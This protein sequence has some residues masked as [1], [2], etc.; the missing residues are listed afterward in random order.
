MEFS[1]IFSW[2][3]RLVNVSLKHCHI[4]D[5]GLEALAE[6]CSSLKVANLSWCDLIT[7]SGISFLSRN[8]RELDTLDINFC[9]NITGIGFLGCSHTLTKLDANGCKL[10]PEGINAIVSGGGIKYL[11]LSTPNEL[12]EVG[13]G[14]MNIQAVLTILKGCPLLQKLFISNF[15]EVINPEGWEAIR[16]S[17]KSL[18]RLRLYGCHKLGKLG[19]HALMDGCVNLC[20]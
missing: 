8:C 6:C 16:Q 15:V 5:K 12:S 1:L 20:L 4:T 2:F 18:K 17:C 11:T 13:E 10:T 14:S 3:P 9:S 7:D 19:W